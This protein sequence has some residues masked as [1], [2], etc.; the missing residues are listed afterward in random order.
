MVLSSEF[1]K[2]TFFDVFGKYAWIL[3]KHGLP[4]PAASPKPG[5]VSAADQK[6][7]GG[8]GG[9]DPSDAHQNAGNKKM[10]PKRF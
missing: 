2:L 5:N 10:G 4:E 1:Q 3:P 7:G 6:V 9:L 8:G